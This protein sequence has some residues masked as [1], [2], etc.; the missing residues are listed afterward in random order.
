MNAVEIAET[1][2]KGIDLTAVCYPG[3][4]GI[5]RT[6]ANDLKVPVRAASTTTFTSGGG[7]TVAGYEG[8]FDLTGVTIKAPM[9]TY[10]PSKLKTGWVALFGY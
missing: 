8:I 2:I 10:Y 9:R 4:N 3:Q 6:L 7:K 1:L 5:A